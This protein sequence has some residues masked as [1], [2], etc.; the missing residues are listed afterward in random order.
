VSCKILGI[1]NNALDYLFSYFFKFNKQC[2]LAH[3]QLLV[4]A[5]IY[6]NFA[7]AVIGFYP[8]SMRDKLI[9]IGFEVLLEVRRMSYFLSCYRIATILLPS[10][11]NFT[12]DFNS[13]ACNT[14]DNLASLGIIAENFRLPY[15][16]MS[17]STSYQRAIFSAY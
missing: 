14:S 11:V 12:F 2:R 8:R 4:D 10:L 3:K 9:V 16:P 6:V 17:T 1:G 13:I 7:L 5:A 15:G